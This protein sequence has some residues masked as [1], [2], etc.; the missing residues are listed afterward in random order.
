MDPRWILVSC[1]FQG[2]VWCSSDGYSAV[3][4]ARSSRVHPTARKPRASGTPAGRKPW[5][6]ENNV[7]SPGGATRFL[8]YDRCRPR[9]RSVRPSDDARF[10][11]SRTLIF[12]FC[13]GTVSAH[14]SFHL[15]RTTV[16]ARP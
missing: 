13:L 11:R 9:G 10:S 5:V 15:I 6:I 16:T 14:L 8:E 4:A 3:G 2:R 12:V 1:L 7:M